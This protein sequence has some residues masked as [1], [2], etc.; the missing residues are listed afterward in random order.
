MISLP[1]TWVSLSNEQRF[2]RPAGQCHKDHLTGLVAAFGAGG[3]P[4]HGGSRQLTP[5][6]QSARGTR[7]RSEPATYLYVVLA[8]V[9]IAGWLGS[10]GCTEARAGKSAFATSQLAGSQL[11]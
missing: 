7:D 1:P 11:R 3:H 6:R 5:V 10:L 4:K 2:T 8:S 9:C